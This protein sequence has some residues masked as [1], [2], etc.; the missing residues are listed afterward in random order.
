[1]LAFVIGAAVV[2]PAMPVRAQTNHVISMTEYV[3]TPQFLTIAPGDT[4]Q[5]QNNGVLPHTATS[6]TSAWTE[7]ILNPGQT[8][9]PPI[10]LTTPGVY[11]YIC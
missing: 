10:T 5:W 8:S 6:N 4:V 2:I 7:I 9:T 11:D 1:M 3:F